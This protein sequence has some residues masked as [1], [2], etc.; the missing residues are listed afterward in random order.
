MKNYLSE[1]QENELLSKIHEAGFKTEIGFYN[2]KTL[3]IYNNIQLGYLNTLNYI[4]YPAYREYNKKEEVIK[5]KEIIK[6]YKRG[7][8]ND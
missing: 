2:W 7:V 8:K 5:V 6:Q 4:F 1:K 3:I